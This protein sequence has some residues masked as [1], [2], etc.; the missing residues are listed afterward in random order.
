MD[1]MRKILPA[2]SVAIVRGDTV[3]LVKRARQ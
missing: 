1:E 2:V 3:L